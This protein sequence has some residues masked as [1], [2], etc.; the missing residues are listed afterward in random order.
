MTKV[1]LHQCK[2]CGGRL[3]IDEVKQ[4]YYCSNCGNTYDYEYFKEDDVHKKGYRFLEA[5]EFVAAKDAFTFSL[6]KDPSDF[7]SLRGFTL[8]EG[9]LRSVADLSGIADERFVFDSKVTDKVLEDCA[10]EH[11]I[12]FGKFRDLYTKAADLTKL[13]DD[14]LSA[15]DDIEDMNEKLDKAKDDLDDCYLHN[16][17]GDAVVDPL[18]GLVVF[19]ILSAL[20]FVG[21]FFYFLSLYA[22]DNTAFIGL[23]D[24][25][26]MFLPIFTTIMALA[27]V[28]K[29]KNYKKIRKDIVKIESDIED[30]KKNEELIEAG[31]RKIE[32]EIEDLVNEITE[33]DKK[34]T[35]DNS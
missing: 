5:G 17:T 7:M 30:M 26:I 6:T 33:A 10:S 23:K 16:K 11:R 9:K 4:L 8:C 24:F 20:L 13:R 32:P 15:A 21:I 28:D 35:A 1:M 34:L 22:K 2:T 25:A 14:R 27:S 31:I 12:Y 18:T 29:C 3:K 19:I